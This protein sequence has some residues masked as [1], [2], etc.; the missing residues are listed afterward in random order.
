MSWIELKESALK[1]NISVV[2]NK[3]SLDKIFAVLKDNAYGHGLFE[4]G[5]L[6]AK[7]G[8]KNA[9]VRDLEEALVV[10]GIFENILCL[11]ETEEFDNIQNIHYAVNSLQTLKNLQS[12]TKIHLK[13]DTG[14]HRNGIDATDLYEA[15]EYAVSNKIEI[16]GVFSH[17]RSADELSSESF[18][19]EKNFLA[20]KKLVL[21]FCTTRGMRIPMFHLQNSAG[22]FR[23]G[24]LGE[25]DMARV[26]IALYGYMDMPLAVGSPKLQP[27][28][29][30]WGNKI[31]SRSISKGEAVGYGGT[32]KIDTDS[33]VSVYDIGY[34]D[35]FLRV[36][37]E[38]DYLLPNGARL[39]GRVSMD[40]ICVESTEDNICLFDNA[41]TFAKR[42]NTIS[43]EII[44]RLNPKI[45]RVIV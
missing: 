4:F 1:Y 6:C 45:K 37:A 5:S 23:S 20:V 13:V 36:K 3:A 17:L 39:I 2:S 26:G 24:S 30:L 10:S 11:A 27:V 41:E 40:N 8:I 42:Y 21:E 33:V 29:S 32:G 43:Y 14:M 35:G 25:F 16:C 34:A 9:I 22:L 38:G 7:Y 28:L 19:Q 18:W 31:S 12:G 44:T 15:L